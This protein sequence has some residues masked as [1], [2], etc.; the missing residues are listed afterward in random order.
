[1][2]YLNSYL[3]KRNIYIFIFLIILVSGILFFRNK[4][5][6]VA[7][8]GES[9][10]I[11]ES[12]NLAKKVGKL[13]FVPKDEVPTIATV[14]NPEDLKGQS[15]FV[16]AKAGDKV[17]IYKNA[18]KAILYDPIADKIITIA[19]LLLGE[20]GSKNN[21]GLSTPVLRY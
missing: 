15:F 18:K 3:T 5:N 10:S 21:P 1:M 20:E 6:P 14:V 11:N 9:I 19:P 8:N 17:L 7:I 4:V 16:D 2:T 12:K 13:M